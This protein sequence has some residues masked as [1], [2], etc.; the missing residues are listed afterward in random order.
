MRI[1]EG[2]MA[3]RHQFI[4]RDDGLVPNSDLPT[5]LYRGV[6]EFENSDEPHAMEAVHAHVS[7]NGW[8]ADWKGSVFRRVHYHSTAH[9]ALVVYR[10]EAQLQLGGR[11]FGEDVMVKRG[12]VLIIPAGVGHER[13]TITKHFLV[14]GLY[15]DE[16]D[17]DLNWGWQKERGNRRGRVDYNIKRVPLPHPK[18]YTDP[19]FG[20]GGPLMDLWKK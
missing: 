18:L 3:N 17:W 6:V 19:I 7:M 11:R 8:R 1:L 12:D 20:P 15:P 5:I 2:A 14:F 9:E 10:G 4:F 16:Q 13:M